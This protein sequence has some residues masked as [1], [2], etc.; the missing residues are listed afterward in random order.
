MPFEFIDIIAT[1]WWVYGLVFF[2]LIRHYA[3]IINMDSFI[4]F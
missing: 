2:I 1:L 3:H 4:L